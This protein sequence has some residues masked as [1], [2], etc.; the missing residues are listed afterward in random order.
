MTKVNMMKAQINV[1][2]SEGIVQSDI[3]KRAGRVN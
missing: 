2:S 1:S 3:A